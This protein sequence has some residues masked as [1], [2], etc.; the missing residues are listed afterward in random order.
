MN[1]PASVSEPLDFMGL[2]D[3]RLALAS[4]RGFSWTQ[5]QFRLNGIDATDSYQPG[6][7]LILPDIEAL[8]EVV[9]RSAFAQSTTSYGTEVGL[10]LARRMPLSK[11]AAQATLRDLRVLS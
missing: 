3:N 4:Q 8:D 10:F 9:V 2:G 1:L 11:V 5:T 7:P 6:R